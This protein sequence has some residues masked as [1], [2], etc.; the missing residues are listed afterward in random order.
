LQELSIALERIKNCRKRC[1]AFAT[2]NQ[3]NKSQR[4]WISQGD[5]YSWCSHWAD[6]RPGVSLFFSKKYSSL[7]YFAFIPGIIAVL[8]IF[9]LKEKKKPVSTLEK[10][11]F[12]S[13]LKYWK[14]AS[15]EYKK[16]VVGLL[17]FA[18]FNSSDVFLLL[19]TK[20]VT[21]NDT[22]TIALISFI[23]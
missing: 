12:F 18:L 16:L 19:I 8:L 5:G 1:V 22:T 6:H 9:L 17:L 15:L 3:R 10:G 11:N 13:F 20:E 2:I 21:G 7:F 14:V 23:I 4:F